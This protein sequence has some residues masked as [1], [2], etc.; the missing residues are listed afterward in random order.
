M[1]MGDGDTL[2]ERLHEAILNGLGANDPAD[3]WDK[4]KGRLRR[5]VYAT[6][7]E[8]VNGRDVVSALTAGSLENEIQ[9]IIHLCSD[10]DNGFILLRNACKSFRSSIY[11]KEAE[12]IL[13]AIAKQLPNQPA[14]RTDAAPIAPTIFVDMT[15]IDDINQASY[16]Q[17]RHVVEAM[18]RPG[19]PLAD[20]EQVEQFLCIRESQD[21]MIALKKILENK[22]QSVVDEF[23]NRLKIPDPGDPHH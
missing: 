21:S 2:N 19:E 7:S 18:S 5:D 8:V 14:F 10:I 1:Q 9:Q 11:R 22:N 13:Q 15:W 16:A 12:S 6:D 17:A 3:A 20:D 4:L 23:R